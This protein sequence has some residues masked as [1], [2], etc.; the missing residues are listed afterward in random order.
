MGYLGY[1]YARIQEKLQSSGRDPLLDTMPSG[2][3]NV[4]E[5]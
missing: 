3:A 1:A 2:S 4:H 5:L